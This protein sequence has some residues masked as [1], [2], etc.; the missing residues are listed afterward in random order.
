M[1][2]GVVIET[3][4]VAGK[5]DRRSPG[6]I[7]AGLPAFGFLLLGLV[8]CGQA[9][10][11]KPDIYLI[12]ID[13]LRK[14]HVGAYG[15]ERDTTPRMDT[16]AQAGLLFENVIAQ[17]S[18][19]LPSMASLMTSR[20]PP[21]IPAGSPVA[22]DPSALTLAEILR[23]H[24]YDTVSITTNPYNVEPVNLMQGF[25]R[26]RLRIAA[27][28]SWVVD[29]M[30]EYLTGRSREKDAGPLF[31]YLH[32][33][34]VHDPIAPPPPYDGLF[35]GDRVEPGVAAEKA[36]ITA[37]YDGAL[38]FIDSEIGRLVDHLESRSS[39]SP[40]VLM[41]TSDHGEEFWD[42]TALGE[43]LGLASVGAREVY[44][45]GHGHTLFPE[46]IEVP[47][48]IAGSGI[49][50][51]RRPSRVRLIDLAPTL[52]GIAG[53]KAPEFSPL[54]VDLLGDHGSGGLA[55]LPALSETRTSAAD[56][57]SLRQ[58][59]MQIYRIGDRNFQFEWDSERGFAPSTTGVS[60]EGL[61][62][63]ERLRNLDARVRMGEPVALT[64]ELR[65]QLIELGY[66][67]E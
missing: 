7:R 40:F 20:H 56:Q 39:G 13:S 43:E 67:E 51:G 12:V 14:D 28:A 55:D 4:S 1:P 45:R 30:L 37:L 24:G 66:I 42:H 50:S 36:R 59:G 9:L 2:A 62:A 54:G 15:Y 35:P 44:G 49:P 57:A 60:P 21:I 16:L 5:C 10:P 58:G 29:R 19:T 48:V 22:L 34:D 63:L 64:P 33:M 6:P 18:W 46:L 23:E 61:D 25:D 47:L 65:E 52:L 3:Q 26:R 31:A 41:I 27:P 32:F 53:V 38:R 17:S 11:P 8:A